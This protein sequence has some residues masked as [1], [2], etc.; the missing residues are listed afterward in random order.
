MSI[1]SKFL[2]LGAALVVTAT[3]TVAATSPAQ[4]QTFSVTV[5][6]ADLDLDS[7][8]GMSTIRARINRAAGQVCGRVEMRDLVQANNFRS[9]YGEAIA[10]A[11]AQLA[12]VTLLASAQPIAVAAASR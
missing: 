11:E 3:G 8:Y 7:A 6:T 2:A 1:A 10:G 12:T 5:P 9:C 4:A